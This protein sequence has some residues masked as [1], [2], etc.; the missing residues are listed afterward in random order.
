MKWM[1]E[2]KKFKRKG[3]TDKTNQPFEKPVKLIKCLQVW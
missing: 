2:L 3:R 1:I